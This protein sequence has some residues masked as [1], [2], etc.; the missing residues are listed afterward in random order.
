MAQQSLTL[1]Q[2]W[3][4]FSD[5]LD[6]LKLLVSENIASSL[7]DAYQMATLGKRIESH[8]WQGLGIKKK[9]KTLEQKLGDKLPGRDEYLP[10]ITNNDEVLFAI[11]YYLHLK[12]F[13]SVK[14]TSS[15]IQQG[16]GNHL[17]INKL[18]PVIASLSLQLRQKISAYLQ[19]YQQQLT[20]D[21]RFKMATGANLFEK[22]LT[23]L[24]A[25][26]LTQA[27]ADNLRL[28]VLS[29]LKRLSASKL[30]R[31]DMVKD[32]SGQLNAVNKTIKAHKVIL[33][34]LIALKKLKETLDN[35]DVSVRQFL[36][37]PNSSNQAVKKNYPQYFD[38]WQDLVS[39]L[40]RRSYAHDALT[41]S[42][43]GLGH[44]SRAV[45]G[46]VGYLLP[47]SNIGQGIDESLPDT[48]TNRQVGL[49]YQAIEQ[50]I[51]RILKELNQ[52]EA[53]AITK[54]SVLN[55]PS[56]HLALLADK[57]SFIT[58]LV[59]LNYQ[60]GQFVDQHLS[61]AVKFAHFGIFG[62]LSKLLSK[63]WFRCLLN[64]TLLL[65]FEAESLQKRTNHII[66]YLKQADS[67]KKVNLAT[68]NYQQWLA[69]Y[70]GK[71]AQITDNSAYLFFRTAHK[72]N[73]QQMQA[74]LETA[75]PCDPWVYSCA[76]PGPSVY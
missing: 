38:Y 19:Q 55:A 34:R 22:G 24:E 49:C 2:W 7:G 31:S 51:E 64:D 66:E 70:Q 26:P 39:K 5:S 72:A 15:L 25:P 18:K 41:K 56:S 63:T 73:A 27:I 14:S 61:G 35:N 68:D 33:N 50:Q 28:T 20:E 60:L 4:A 53:T 3:Q 65:I 75:Y 74:L 16:I 71:T 1:T 29:Q 9:I 17:G 57:L 30:T 67:C 54:A 23:L 13:Q 37:H 36:R 43:R 47:T 42:V 40:P 21:V 69:V 12:R 10:Q 52:P 11:N 32:L 48:N 58:Q 76:C 8:V 6:N 59:S 46:A 45:V 44:T 62:F